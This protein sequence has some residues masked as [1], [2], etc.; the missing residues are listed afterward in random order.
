MTPRDRFLASV[1]KAVARRGEK[2]DRRAAVW[3][4]IVWELF[5]V[6]KFA[7]AGPAMLASW[8]FWAFIIPGAL[9]AAAAGLL[10]SAVLQR[11]VRFSAWLYS[12]GVSGEKIVRV[13][14]QSLSWVYF[15]LVL[16]WPLLLAHLAWRWLGLDGAPP[17]P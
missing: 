13:S 9:F 12:R 15:G 5:G 17:L 8:K 10:P 3:S 11:A 6:W 14:Q 4:V 2:A 16:G 7:L 1:N